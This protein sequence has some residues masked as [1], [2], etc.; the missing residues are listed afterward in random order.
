[1]KKMLFTAL[2]AACAMTACGTKTTET[3]AAAEE[4]TREIG[5]S[6]IAYVQVEAVLAQC[7]LFLNEGKALQEKTQKAQKS[8]AQKEQNLQS[9]AAQLQEKYQKGLI[10][11][12]DAQA[13][14]QSIEKRVAAYQSSAQK[15]AQA[16][17]EENFVFTNRAQDLLHRAVQDIN[18][19]K[20]YKLIINST[21]L[22]DADTT[23]NITPAV[24]AKVNELYA[25]D[26]KAEKK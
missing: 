7:D 12:N 23:L 20:K 14:Q 5:S 13:Q 11:T 3:A 18:A 21:A 16:L 24:L 17:D 15:E 1:M 26:Q 2:V 4:A 22:I 19:G 9:E 10:T 8:W 6:D 25:A